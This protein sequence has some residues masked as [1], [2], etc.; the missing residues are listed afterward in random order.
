MSQS[1]VGA[2]V[3]LQLI[4]I[5]AINSFVRNITIEETQMR[6]GFVFLVIVV[7]GQSFCGI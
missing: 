4:H 1:E 6:S 3:I 5:Q 2:Y 7:V